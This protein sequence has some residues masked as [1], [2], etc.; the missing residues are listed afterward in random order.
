MA[1]Y[2]NRVGVVKRPDGGI[3]ITRFAVE[4]MKKYNFTDEDGFMTWYMNRI[5]PGVPFQVISE[6]DIPKNPDG[7]WDKNQRNEWSLIAGKVQVDPVKV[8]VKQA[9]EAQKQAVLNKLGLTKDEFE[10]LK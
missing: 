8:A 10:K 2:L 1:N 3:S 7:Q 4:D 5:F 6:N 9:K